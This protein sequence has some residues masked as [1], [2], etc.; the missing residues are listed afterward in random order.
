MR[1]R[2]LF[3]LSFA[4]S[5]V[6]FAAG[7]SESIVARMN[8]WILTLDS[9]DGSEASISKVVGKE[10]YVG[11]ISFPYFWDYYSIFLRLPRTPKGQ[12]SDIYIEDTNPGRHGCGERENIPLHEGK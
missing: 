12:K 5:H 6:A 8:G 11:M 4:L 1:A 10:H 2:T 7:G 3:L 9:G